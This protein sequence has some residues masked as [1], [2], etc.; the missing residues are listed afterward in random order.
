MTR[1]VFDW[2]TRGMKFGR[3][4]SS[5]SNTEKPHRD[6]HDH[7]HP[8]F[9]ELSSFSLVIGFLFPETE[10]LQTTCSALFLTSANQEDASFILEW[11]DS[12]KVTCF[13]NPC[14]IIYDLELQTHPQ[15]LCFIWKMGLSK[16][17]YLSGLPW[18]LRWSYWYKS[19]WYNGK[20]FVNDNVYR[21]TSLE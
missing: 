21:Y 20:L 14:F 5:G 15:I 19:T 6:F 12:K 8:S 10:D 7:P 2:T 18:R 17:S 4:V 13:L 3:R 11:R 16:T 9:A 1:L